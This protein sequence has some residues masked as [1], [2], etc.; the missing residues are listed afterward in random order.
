MRHQS[1]TQA[2]SDLPDPS[3]T[4]VHP[5]QLIARGI[6][7]P[8]IPRPGRPRKYPILEMEIGDSFYIPQIEGK[9][10]APLR[11]VKTAV[12]AQIRILAGL[13]GLPRRFAFR[14]EDSGWRCWRVQ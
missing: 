4:A 2:S 6:T 3:C 8:P 14:Q 12:R 13:P 5:R 9:G 7:L 11:S 1:N 10:D